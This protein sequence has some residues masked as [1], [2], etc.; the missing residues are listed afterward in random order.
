ME[1]KIRV[2]LSKRTYNL[3]MKDAENFEFFKK[4]GS[5]NKNAFINKLIVN[6]HN[7]YSV[8]QREMLDVIE[9]SLFEL[10]DK[11]SL[12]EETAYNIL[13]KLNLYS[14]GNDEYND[15]HISF[16]PIRESVN[17]IDFIE[18]HEL[19]G[20]SRSNYYRMM[21][22]SYCS[23]PQDKRERIIFR[24]IIERIEE[25]ISEDKKIYL[26]TKNNYKRGFPGVTLS[27]Y[28]L[29]LTKEELY[30]YLLAELNDYKAC[31]TTRLCRIQSISVLKEKRQFS[32]EV[33]DKLNKMEING[34]QYAYGDDE[35]ELIRI[36]LSEEGIRKYKSYYVHR[37]TPIEIDGDCY[38]F[39]CSY[40]QALNYFTRFG[41]DAVVLSPE[42]LKK[43]F[44]EFYR[45]GLNCFD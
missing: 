38:V 23:L 44:K 1:E 10:N 42:P 14:S 26:L 5:L 30:N 15:V 34:P 12:L 16:R 11:Y 27:P 32:K 17:I 31:R 24:N 37:P 20:S 35:N 3:L 45:K 36:S 43:Q 9:D 29:C 13:N 6:Y 2:N 33:L 18:N 7:D 21:F 39:N 4:D 25:A 41:E 8:S 19:K 22:D 28:S 40:M